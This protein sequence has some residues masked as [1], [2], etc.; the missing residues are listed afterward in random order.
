MAKIVGI[1]FKYAGKIYYFDPKGETFEEGS[2]VIVETA[3]GLE[4]GTVALPV[5][6]VPDKDVV[7][8]LKPIVRK[9]SKKDEEN[10]E[11]FAAKRPEAMA[12]AEEKIRARELDMKLIDCEYTF[13]GSKIIFY[14]TAEGRVDFRDLVR[15][16]AQAFHV[17]IELRQ[18]GIR[19]EAKLLGGLAPCG[20]PCC[21]ASFLQDFKKVSIKMAK[22]QGLSLNPGKISGLCGR[23]MCCLEYENEYYSDVYKKMPKIGSEVETPDGKGSVVSNNMLKLITRVKIVHADK[24]EVYRDYPVAELKW[25]KRDN[26]QKAE[27]DDD[28]EDFKELSD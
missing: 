23:L 11:K 28:E 14:F 22:T 27:K 19:D 6:E 24:S 17:R 15:D 13:D 20:R 8:P 3:K 2:G 4:Y 5:R 7:Q 12:L 1:K 26:G 16:L 9:A 21:C 10:R 25:T 18:V